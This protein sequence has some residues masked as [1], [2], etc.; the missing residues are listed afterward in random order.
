MSNIL[1]QRSVSQLLISELL[2]LQFKRCNY[3][4]KR[5]VSVASIFSISWSTSSSR[6]HEIFYVWQH[7]YSTQ[8]KIH[9]Y[10]EFKQFIQLNPEYMI[11]FRASIVG[12][13]ADSASFFV[14]V[15]VQNANG[16][17]QEFEWLN[18]LQQWSVLYMWIES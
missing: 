4:G 8:S 16:Y 17:G 1:L 12:I 2:L 15:Y 10:L 14:I 11:I 6:C 13:S 5:D 18:W 3:I 9:N 7:W